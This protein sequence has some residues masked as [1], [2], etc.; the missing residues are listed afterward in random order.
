MNIQVIDNYF[1]VRNQEKIQNSISFISEEEANNFINLQIYANDLSSSI[2]EKMILNIPNLNLN[3][4]IKYLKHYSYN[5]LQYTHKLT[6]FMFNIGIV[7]WNKVDNVFTFKFMESEHLRKLLLSM[8]KLFVIKDFIDHFEKVFKSIE[9]VED[10]IKSILSTFSGSPLSY[11]Y[12]FLFS[13]TYA[14]YSETQYFSINNL[15]DKLYAEY[16]GDH[17]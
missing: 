3:Q 2:S 9:S 14:C 17:F 4:K 8:P 10:L 5:I 12:K 15:K 6:G 1:L 13:N 16:I 7:V 11:H